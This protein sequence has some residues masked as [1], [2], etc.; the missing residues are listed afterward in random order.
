MEKDKR[1]YFDLEAG[2]KYRASLHNI[3]GKLDVL[4]KRGDIVSELE[5]PPRRSGFG[6]SISGGE[7]LFLAIAT[8]YCNDLYREGKK[9]GIQVD[10][11]EVHV[12]GDFMAAGHPA[13]NVQCKIMVTAQA[14]EDK[15]R[16]LVAH[17]DKI[18]EIPMSI[19]KGTAISLSEVVAVSVA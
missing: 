12:D 9:L 17:T 5:L 4:M 8:C 10:N 11:V 2:M 7:I 15:I 19:R 3:D 6:S 13:E 1:D 14:S 18:A 16:E